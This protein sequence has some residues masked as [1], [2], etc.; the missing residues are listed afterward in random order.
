MPGGLERTARIVQPDVDALHEVTADVDVVV[1][2]EH[3]LVGETARAHHFGDLLQHAFAG[4]VARM[5][6]AGKDELHRAFRIV[7]HR[8][9]PLE[10]L[11]NQIGALIGGKTARE[12]DREGIGTE[13]LAERLNGF[14]GS[15][16]RRACAVAR[17]RTN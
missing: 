13:H 6:F 1:F 8:G 10:I 4:L 14:G 12:A 16:R 15:P 5:G 2:D 7:D 3:E 17:A 11:Q 9:E